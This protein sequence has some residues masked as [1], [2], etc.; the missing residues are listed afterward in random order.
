MRNISSYQPLNIRNK[1]QCGKGILNE[2]KNEHFQ[3]E[4]DGISSISWTDKP[5]K[6]YYGVHYKDAH[7]ISILY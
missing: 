2:V 5:Y 6:T 4:F 7:S 1:S 3:G